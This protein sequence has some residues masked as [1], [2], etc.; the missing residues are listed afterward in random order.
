MVQSRYAA[1]SRFTGNGVVFADSRTESYDGVVPATGFGPDLRKLL[2][3]VKGVLDSRGMPV[4]T[5]QATR[6]VGLFAQR[7]Y[8]SAA[9]A[10]RQRGNCARLALKRGKSAAVPKPICARASR[11]SN[12]PR[13]LRR[14]VQPPTAAGRVVASVSLRGSIEALGQH[15]PAALDP[16]GNCDDRSAARNIAAG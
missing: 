8:F 6:A 7:A 9:R 14:H 13:A 11:I 3:E 12:E 2:P 10:P 16:K 1:V 5:G 15:F 4:A